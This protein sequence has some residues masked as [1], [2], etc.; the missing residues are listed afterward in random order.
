MRLAPSVNRRLAEAKERRNLTAMENIA[1]TPV[2]AAELRPH[3]SLGRR[4]FA[5]LIGAVAL[6]N[7]G[8]GAAFWIAGAWPVMGFCGLEVLLL[9][10]AFRYN[11]AQARAREYVVLDEASL[12]IRQV[13]AAGRQRQWQMQP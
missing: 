8:A 2:F 6:M 12:T 4:G 13:S 11:Y 3:R 7:F 10:L 9:W 1:A 5:I